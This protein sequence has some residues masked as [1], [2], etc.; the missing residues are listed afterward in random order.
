[1]NLIEIKALDNGAHNNQNGGISTVPE[2]WAIIPEDMECENFPF[3]NVT[4]EEIDGVMT[5]TSWEPLPMPEP[6]P[7]PEPEPTVEERVAALENAIAD[8]LMLY[9]EDLGNG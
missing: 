9:E 7:E 5:V 6:E 4:V 3:G 2:G 1:M 8:G